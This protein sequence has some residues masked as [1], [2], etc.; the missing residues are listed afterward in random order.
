M[1]DLLILFVGVAIGAYLHEP[2][3]DAV[4]LLDRKEVEVEQ[5]AV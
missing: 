5:S 3:I 4:P 1:N 2:I